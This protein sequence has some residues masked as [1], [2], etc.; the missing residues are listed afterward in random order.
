MANIHFHVFI[1]CIIVGWFVKSQ[2]LSYRLP[3]T[4]HPLEYDLTLF[5]HLSELSPFTFDGW[6]TIKMNITRQHM[7]SNISSYFTLQLN[8]G[9]N[10]TINQ[11]D[12]TLNL[13]LLN[14]N[15]P[16]FVSLISND[17]TEITTF[18]FNITNT[19]ILSA[20]ND[21]SL[22]YF[23]GYFYCSYSSPLIQDARRGLYRSSYEYN[24]TMIHGTATQMEPTYT[25]R[26][27]P[28]FD[29]PQW[30]CIFHITYIAPINAI[31]IGNMDINEIINYTDTTQYECNY[32]SSKGVN[33]LCKMVQFL[34]TPPMPSYLL[35][36]II[37]EY[38]HISHVEINKELIPNGNRINFTSS[39]WMQLSESEYF[40]A[41][42]NYSVASLL[43]FEKKLQL[44]YNLNKLDQIAVV[45]YGGGMENW[46]LII[47]GPQA[48]Y[49]EHDITVGSLRP[50][51]G[52]IGHE[53]AHQ[54]FGNDVTLEWWNHLWIQE[55]FARYFEYIVGDDLRPDLPFISTY[56]GS[57]WEGAFRNSESIF[58]IAAVRENVETQSDISGQFNQALTYSKGASIAKFMHMY[59]GEE[60]FYKGLNDFFMTY[61]YGIYTTDTF[62]GIFDPIINEVD[63]EY[64]NE[65]MLATKMFGSYVKQA[66]FPVLFVQFDEI[67]SDLIKVTVTQLRMVLEGPQFYNSSNN[68]PYYDPGIIEEFAQQLWY[69]PYRIELANG[70]ILMDFPFNTSMKSFDIN[71][72]RYNGLE[73]YLFNPDVNSFFR[74]AYD[75]KSFDFIINSFDKL[76][77]LS[78]YGLV[79]DQWRL[80]RSNY[81]SA[82]LY[83]KF[84]EKIATPD[85]IT[86]EYWNSFWNIIIDSL[87]EIDNLLCEYQ[88]TSNTNETLIKYRHN[89]RYF[90]RQ[91]LDKL[92]NNIGGNDWYINETMSNDFINLKRKLI[93]TFIQIGDSDVIQHGL[94]ILLNSNYK[95]LNVTNGVIS[96]INSNLLQQV[97]MASF[98]SLNQSVY[99]IIIND[100]FPKSVSSQQNAILNAIGMVYLDDFMVQKAYD[101]IH[102]L[103][104][105]GQ[106]NSGYRNLRL[107][108]GRGIV[109]NNMMKNDFEDWIEYFGFNEG[110]AKSLFDTFASNDIYDSIYNLFVEQGIL[111]EATTDTNQTLEKMYMNAQ[112]I[113]SN[114]EMLIG[115]LEEYVSDNETDNE[116]LP[117][118][119][120]TIMGIVILCG[121]VG[122]CYIV[123]LKKKKKTVETT[124]YNEMNQWEIDN[125][126]Y[127]ATAT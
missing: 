98:A 108:S 37:G 55:G 82:T 43:W 87:N 18:S 67:N 5:P 91:I 23:I 8:K 123:L 90:V 120:Y 92:W 96:D 32:N 81:V 36:F 42:L 116:W 127:G 34:P 22:S 27:L 57:I 105:N 78:Q 52:I 114:E 103:T 17:I 38:D 11:N 107:C 47:Y 54:Y 85:I 102:N 13:T 77:Y 113:V 72:V 10:I 64:N 121:I 24:G 15:Q 61:Y 50:K 45:Q 31:T 46:G 28:L 118:V 74:V 12:I 110:N 119:I 68:N 1:W 20:M 39:I 3:S 48:L 86:E 41:S 25:R 4:I 89:Y 106:R 95:N 35:A 21:Q 71:R 60:L 62:L 101:F 97:F 73:Y 111:N 69:I 112:W 16:N 99:N 75:E 6:V 124:K 70:N 33:N 49:V 100:I 93:Q 122:V 117:V 125:N 83:L 58:T 66:G 79:S 94:N 29:E 14:E 56:Y 40:Y 7:L 2:L 126:L 26:A 80:M 76:S 30:R 104:D 65:P 84:I 51:F 63:Y 59:V 115:F 44:T 88:I 9:I 53:I 19:Y 109:W